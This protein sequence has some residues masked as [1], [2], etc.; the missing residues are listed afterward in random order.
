MSIV[1]YLQSLAKEVGR[2]LAS[3]KAN[4]TLRK[5]KKIYI[6]RHIKELEYKNGRIVRCVE[7]FFPIIR[8][9]WD[10]RYLSDVINKIR[11]S[12][13]YEK[14]YKKISEEYSLSEQQA[15]VY[16]SKFVH[17]CMKCFLNNNPNKVI[18][19]I[20]TFLNDLEDGTREW[21]VKAFIK[22]IGLEAEK[23]KISKNAL[24]RKPTPSDF[25]EETPLDVP[26]FNKLTVFPSA[27]L[28]INLRTKKK[29][30]LSIELE[31]L[32]I[33][34]RLYKICSLFVL[35]TIWQPKSILLPTQIYK[36]HFNARLNYTYT[37]ERS[38][39]VHL[40][41]FVNKISSLLPLDENGKLLFSDPCS[42]AILRYQDA[43][44]KSENIENKIAYGIMGLEALYL[45]A[46][47]RGELSHRLAQRVAKTI[48]FFGEQ[49]IKLYTLI[50]KGYEIR[51]SFVHG[52]CPI[53]EKEEKLSSLL[54]NILECLRKSIILFLQLR[55][56]KEKEKFITIID[57]SMLD[58]SVAA[59]LKKLLE[60]I[61]IT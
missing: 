5:T 1:E 35:E 29:A 44:L 56:Y 57:N 31:K 42:I 10:W 50:K 58:D 16:L 61:L 30:L 36:T 22:G 45:K 17:E 3:L 6:K 14:T 4:N 32:V 39:E 49:P 19:V 34:L 48:G 20:F 52:S 12:S 41:K 51:S 53:S 18:E 37:I 21:K 47:E 28:E 43:L 59:K 23:I 54:E 25:E 8:E 26:I 27:I 7:L 55:N 24:L 13:L 11:S 2:L 9:E 60:E 33:A 38:E 40:S 46:D 15:D